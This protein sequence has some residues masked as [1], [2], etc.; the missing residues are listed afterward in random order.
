MR[1]GDSGRPSR[2]IKLSIFAR[3][4]LL[5][6]ATAIILV[7]TMSVQSS[8][9]VTK[10]AVSGV[11]DKA[12]V[13]NRFLSA[14]SA[15]G[16][17]FGRSEPVSD[18]LTSARDL[19]EGLMT[20]ALAVDRDAAIVASVT[21][22][23]DDADRFVAIARD[24][25]KTGTT[26][27]SGDGLLRAD[28]IVFGAEREIIGA[29]AT[30]WSAETILAGTR[31][32]KRAIL[33]VAG[34]TLAVALAASVLLLR[35]TVSTPIR[36]VGAAMKQ[37]V[38]GDHDLAIPDTDRND[39]IGLIARDLEYFR[40]MMSS[41]SEATKSAVFQ[42]AAFRSSSTAMIL[43]DKDFRITLTNAAFDALAHENASGFRELHPGFSTEDLVGQSVDIFHRN[44][45][46]A[47]GLVSEPGTR[48]MSSD[49]RVGA[50]IMAI[51]INAI[52]DNDGEIAGYVAEWADVTD[53]RRDA[54][55]LA[56]LEAKQVRIQF[57]D[58]WTLAGGNAQFDALA[59]GHATI[60]KTAQTF[61]FP[62]G[63]SFD[64]LA[65]QLARGEAVIGRFQ[66][67]F[68]S[69]REALVDGSFC[70]IMDA[71]GCSAGTLLLGLDI[72][73]QDRVLADA[74]RTR[75]EMQ[76]AQEGVV[77]ALR[78]G[79]A[80]LREGDLT[81]SLTES[82]SPE[83][84][85]LREDFNAASRGLHDTI[86]DVSEMAAAMRGEVQ[87]IV[88]AADDL[89]R[90]TEQQAATLEETAAA[91]AEIT[92]AV[93]SASEGARRATEVVTEA[94]G[95]AE[96]S[97][98]IVGDAVSAMDAIS[99]SSDQIS[100]II[101]VIDDI[102]FQTN[103]LALNA[104]V[105]AARAGDAG[106][107]F[108]VVASEVRALAQRSSEAAREISDLITTSGQHVKS[109]AHLVGQAGEALRQ[110]AA[111]VTGISDHVTEIVSSSQ[112]QSTSLTEV[113]SA[114][115]QLDQVTQQNAAMFEETTA[116]SH[117]LVRQA[118]QLTAGIAR[119]R[120]AR[121]A[122]PVRAGSDFPAGSGDRNPPVAR[123]KSA[124]KPRIDGALALDVE[125]DDWSDF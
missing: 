121:S 60:G 124:P 114:M 63:M 37:V 90:R 67:D 19:S 35:H 23:A 107:G 46:R 103:L 72:T 53:I 7:A 113:N 1:P 54:A 36:R 81:Y 118:D 65:A 38:S 57:D 66:L 76:A 33:T 89:S 106:R 68:G 51:G 6:A 119:F 100:K 55:A 94:R 34:V 115:G 112:E 109:G 85:Q 27:A 25:M 50:R 26:A 71:N 9:L 98:A 4:A 21:V 110:I 12:N 77:D 32:S 30:R 117:A 92:A 101:G 49:I 2:A 16:I 108:A 122:P 82:L 52:H 18:V 95:N 99:S 22:G 20:G 3:C 120:V 47:R 28:P 64:G 58:S 91:V 62:D 87:D 78:T 84:E 125:D 15:G 13:V 104:G 44:A 39:E 8:K 70:P 86:V 24:A 45:A 97:G 96:S 123:A 41:A 40:G 5:I 80:R 79:L 42:R 61:V 83:Y 31:A 73:E 75:H 29:V 48:P 43:A 74:E 111:S 105:E 17:R 14:Q 56:G 59:S 116:A 10:V 69:G 11:V 93:G 88:A 102:A